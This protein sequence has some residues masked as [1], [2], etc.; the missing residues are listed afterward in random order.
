MNTIAH[1]KAE[2]ASELRHA[3]IRL[4]GFGND[5]RDVR[6]EKSVCVVLLE[7]RERRRLG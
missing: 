1:I 3:L 4:A 5:L 7:S 2:T 6:L